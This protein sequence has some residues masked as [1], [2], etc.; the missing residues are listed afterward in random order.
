ME[1]TPEEQRIQKEACE[2]VLANKDK[3]IEQFITSKKPLPVNFATIF[4]A[5]SPGAGKTEFSQRYVPTFETKNDDI[6]KSLKDAGLEDPSQFDTMLIRIDVDEIR[7]FLPQYQKTDADKGVKGN[8][9]VIQKAANKGLD[10]LRDYAFKNNISFLHDGTFGNLDTM[11]SLIKKSLADGRHVFIFY[12][13]IDPKCAWD[14]TKAREVV[15]GRNIRADKFI[16]QYF[17]SK[18]NV[19]QIKSEFPDVKIN[20]ILKNEKN[21]VILTDLNIESVDKALKTQYNKGTLKEY[22]QEDLLQITSGV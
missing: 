4:M 12:I 14:F 11:R 7:T 22:T 19:D 13:Y 15:E 8:S 2:F 9:H 17:A 5:G 18:T 20:F 6:F 1:L 21:E 10:I 16:E 3:L